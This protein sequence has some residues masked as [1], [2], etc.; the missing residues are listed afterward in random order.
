MFTHYRTR[1]FILKRINRGEA[2]QLFTVYT[3]DFGK[4]KVLGRAI[5]KISSK[6]RSATDFFYLSE[7]EFIQAKANKTLTDAILIDKF[8]N[9]RKDLSKLA[10]ARRI[11]GIFDRL[12]KGQE[13]DE[14][15]WRLLKE[16]FDKLNGRLTVAGRQL[17]YYYFLWNFLS[18]LGYQPELYHCPFCQ[19]KIRPENIYFS[20]KK[21]GL[22]CGQCRD[23]TDPENLLISANAVKII[24]IL[25]KEDAVIV[26][27][28]KIESGDFDFLK[29]ISFRYLA[30]ILKQN[31]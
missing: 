2:D 5:R 10:L 7:I 28:L 25:L 24:R 8:E 9:L 16:I 12:I 20:L 29:K 4:L 14:K 3:K 22:V 31:E 17:L 15:L 21:S 6:L 27:Q 11:S 19:K 1:A 23:K 18:F 13:P 30:E 26:G